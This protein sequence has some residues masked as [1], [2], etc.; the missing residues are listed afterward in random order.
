MTRSITGAFLLSLT[1]LSASWL[2][3]DPPAKRE[4]VKVTEAALKLHRESLIF[5]GHNDLPWELRTR[6]GGGFVSLDISH[7]LTRLHTDIPRLREGGVG[8]Q[9]WS[10]Y[11]PVSSAAKGKA[12][13]QTLEQI[14]TIHRMIARYPETFRFAGS[15]DDVL[16]ARREG[17]IA[18]LI[19]V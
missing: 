15:A 18:S 17:K 13:T 19:G 8:A 14:D 1:L 6:S 4:P 2:H 5:D 16:A 11:V 3:A 7:R 9:F 12:V 10:A